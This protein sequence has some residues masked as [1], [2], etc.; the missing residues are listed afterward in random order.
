MN[1]PERSQAEP[2]AGR[3]SETVEE[4]PPPDSLRHLLDDGS[5]LADV[6]ENAPIPIF[7]KSREDIFVFA[8]QAY[9]TAVGRTLPEVL[10]RNSEDLLGAR[11]ARHSRHDDQRAIW[12]GKV[13]NRQ[14]TVWLPDGLGHTFK[15]V[16]FPVR[17]SKGNALGVCGLTLDVSN[18]INSERVRVAERE[19]IALE[20]HD[21]AVQVMAATALRLGALQRSVEDE[22]QRET[23]RD[24]QAGVTESVERLRG[25]LSDLYSRLPQRDLWLAIENL[26]ASLRDQ[27]GLSFTFRNGLAENPE[28]RTSALIIALLKEALQNVA[29]HAKA[30]GVEVSLGRR[31]DGIHLSVADDGVGFQG[32]ES[33]DGHLGLT[34]MRSRVNAVGGRFDLTSSSTGTCIEVWLPEPFEAPGLTE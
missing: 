23:L 19:R 10:G 7:I 14:E 28:E 6:L 18:S 21:D 2:P 12:T 31:S 1:H 13:V 26:A 34:S 8:N 24:I 4:A 33:P 22:K 25:V 5:L 16:K 3:G 29:K 27:H 9:L 20:I 32:A 30:S 11:V 15:I 17:D